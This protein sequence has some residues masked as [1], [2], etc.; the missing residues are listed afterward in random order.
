[1]TPDFAY[2]EHCTDTI[3]AFYT[4]TNTTYLQT[5]QD[6]FTRLHDNAPNNTIVIH[7]YPAQYNYDELITALHH[8]NN[9]FDALDFLSYFTH[10]PTPALPTA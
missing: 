8:P 6:C 9:S 2:C 3:A 1:M 4:K 5:C 7:D 10:I